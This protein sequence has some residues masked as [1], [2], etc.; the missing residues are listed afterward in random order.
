MRMA[1]DVH[2]GLWRAVLLSAAGALVG[3]VAVRWLMFAHGGSPLL[4]MAIVAAVLFVLVLGALV[5]GGR[6]GLM[7]LWGLLLVLWTMMFV[8]ALRDQRGGVYHAIYFLP[9]SFAAWSVFALPVAAATALLLHRT[10][11][12][13]P[14]ALLGVMG[15]WIVLAVASAIVS[16][17][18]PDVGGGPRA[19]PLVAW[20]LNL[21]LPVAPF[22]L[23]GWM[24]LRL[25]RRTRSIPPPAPG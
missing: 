3:G 25:R 6:R 15:V 24:M 21:L 1:S 5:L 12:A 8:G 4:E 23:G 2:A 20:P 16:R 9:D 10:H 22:V 17:Y 18:A 14:R 13:R 7:L 19:N 11:E